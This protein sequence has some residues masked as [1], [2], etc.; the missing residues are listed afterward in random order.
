MAQLLFDITRLLD[1]GWQ[2]RLP[3]GI[4]RVALEYLRHYGN[5]ARALVRYRGRWLL[6]DGRDSR[7]L[8]EALLSPDERFRPAV[9]WCVARA[10]C[11][12]APG[13]VAGAILVNAGHSGLEHISYG[14]RTAKLRLRPVFVLHDLIPITHP[15]YCR[16]GEADRHHRRLTTMLSTAEGIVVNSSA[17]LRELDARAPV[18][19]R[20]SARCVVAPLGP[21][22]LPEPK[23]TRPLPAPYFVMLGTIEPRKNHLMVLH[24]WRELALALRS[25]TPRLVLIGQRGWE[26]E[27]VV[28]LLERCEALRELVVEQPSC[29]DEDL[30]TWLHHAQALLFPSFAE[31]FGMPLLEAYHLGVPVIASELPVFREIAADVPEYLDPLDGSGWKRAIRE[32][33]LP[34]S[35]RRA[36]QVER[37]RSLPLPTW[38]Q[39]FEKADSLLAS[40]AADA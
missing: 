31:G 25:A 11:S 7:R 13:P 9:A 38:E 29:S 23:V 14:R 20:R 12:V 4:D 17:T 34:D 10:W 6:P 8:F 40:I 3:T 37:I 27:Q 15:E 18:S 22:R 24:V 21:A 36:A 28:D 33:A 19:A 5:R 1:R 16:P 39:H 30:A 26:C 2:G 32:F 35:R